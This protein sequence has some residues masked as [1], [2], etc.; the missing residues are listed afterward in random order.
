MISSLKTHSAPEL[1]PTTWD[2]RRPRGTCGCSSMPPEGARKPSGGIDEH[3]QVPLGLLLSHVVGESSGA[4]CVFNEDIIVGYV[5][6]DN[7][8]HRQSGQRAK[9]KRQKAKGLTLGLAPLAI[10]SLSFH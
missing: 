5:R 10:A 3:P 6:S 1:S 2:R 4:E 9:V 7:A 8:G